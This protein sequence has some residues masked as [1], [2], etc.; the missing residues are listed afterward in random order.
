[1]LI[2]FNGAGYDY[3]LIAG[4]AISSFNF[5]GLAGAGFL[6]WVD[7]ASGSFAVPTEILMSLPDSPVVQGFGSGGVTVSGYKVDTFDAPGIDQGFT[8]FVD[9]SSSTVDFN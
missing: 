5:S 7:P 9:S 1:M 4:T 2:Q 8:L 3:V 6:C